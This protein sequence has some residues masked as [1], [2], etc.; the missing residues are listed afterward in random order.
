MTLEAQI[1]DSVDYLASA[2][3]VRSL[4]A[5]VYWP[6]WHSPWWHMLLLHE[7]GETRR[8]PDTA[9]E[10]TIEV[11]VRFP[12][13]IFP[14]RP[15]EMPP[16]MD[17]HRH[18]ACHC[19]LGSIYQV[20]GERGI[21]VDARLPWIRPWF[22]RYQMA[23]GG[24]NC[25]AGAYLV[26]DECPSS[27]VGTIAAFEAVLRYSPRGWTPQD[28]RFLDGAA[29]F[30]IER[31]LMLGSATR[32][33]A[34]ERESALSWTKL[35]FP[36]FYFYD[37]LRG[38]TALLTWS[39][40]TGAEVPLAALQGAA[41]HLQEEFGAGDVRIGRT[42]YDGTRT[43]LQQPDGTWVRAD[44]TFFPLLQAVSRVGDV[45]PFLTR[46]WGRARAMVGR[47]LG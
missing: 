30:L 5:D 21:D 11:L 8:I 37:V 14:I 13:K 15:D 43:R 20:L 27:M 39:Q 24:L 47:A 10:N 45:S 29:H 7:M 3:A 16:A 36:R 6:K 38:L 23:D 4:A 40:M 17:P 46:E 1:H 22:H 9:I 12:L 32:H 18:V 28:R 2:D 34:E 42:C 26:T 44:A 19:Q 41:R 35:C 33:N 31:K 25:D